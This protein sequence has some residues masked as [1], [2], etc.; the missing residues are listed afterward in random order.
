[1]YI[2]DP[3]NVF[4]I[5]ATDLLSG[6]SSLSPHPFDFG[7]EFSLPDD[8]LFCPKSGKSFSNLT[9]GSDWTA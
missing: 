3:A 4:M 5:W 6:Y 1:M 9:F 7:Y 8:R 2:P